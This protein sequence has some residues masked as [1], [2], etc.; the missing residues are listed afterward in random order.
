MKKSIPTLLLAAVLVAGC[1][2]IGDSLKDFEGSIYDQMADWGSDYCGDVTPDEPEK[3]ALILE[4]RIEMS[5]EVRQRG[6]NGPGPA[7]V[8]YLD[9]QTANGEGPVVVIYCEGETVPKG[10][11]KRL[12][13]LNG[14]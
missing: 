5:R 6:D 8:D 11:W 13:R 2:G 1:S 4:E 10:V 9:E 3:Y 14:G 12:V 7:G